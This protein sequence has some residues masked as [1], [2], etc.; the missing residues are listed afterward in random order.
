M[1]YVYLILS[2]F[3]SASSSVFGKVFNR[4]NE[5]CKDSSALYNLL[6]MSSV[7]ISWGLLFVTDFSFETSVLLYSLGFSVCYT[8][9]NVGLINALK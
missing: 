6:L 5:K 2:V 8:V 7:C 9:C 3:M 1:P 4:S